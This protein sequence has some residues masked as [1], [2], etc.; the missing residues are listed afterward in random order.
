MV[1]RWGEIN[2]SDTKPREDAFSAVTVGDVQDG[3]D[4]RHVTLVW[5]SW[6]A[7]IDNE[8][9]EQSNFSNVKYLRLR[10]IVPQ[11]ALSVYPRSENRFPI[12]PRVTL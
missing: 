3:C 5:C 11:T 8:T 7:E 2:G 12:S 9:V 1:V 4:G 10:W 6:D